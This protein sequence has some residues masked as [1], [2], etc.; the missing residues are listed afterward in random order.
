ME[1]KAMEMVLKRERNH[2]NIKKISLRK[3]KN[4]MTMKM[5]KLR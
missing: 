3:T 5:M 2:L 1:V 4:K